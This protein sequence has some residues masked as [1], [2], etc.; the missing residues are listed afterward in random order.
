[1]QT[2]KGASATDAG[3]SARRLADDERKPDRET[4]LQLHGQTYDAVATPTKTVNQ[5]SNRFAWGQHQHHGFA[6]DAS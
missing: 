4:P 5:A 1:L 3:D 2:T 6:L